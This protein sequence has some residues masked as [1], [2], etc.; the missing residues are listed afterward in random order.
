MTKKYFRLPNISVWIVQHKCFRI[1]Q[2]VLVGLLS[3]NVVKFDGI[4]EQMLELGILQHRKLG[5]DA[6]LVRVWAV[7]N[8]LAKQ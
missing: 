2:K 5:W 3:R 8:N 4:G 7:H 6:A 1:V